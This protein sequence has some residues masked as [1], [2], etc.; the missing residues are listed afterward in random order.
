VENLKVCFYNFAKTVC[1]IKKGKPNKAFCYTTTNYGKN[2]KN[3]ISF[4]KAIKLVHMDV[5]QVSPYQKKKYLW[6]NINDEP[7]IEIHCWQLNKKK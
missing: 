6:K 2:I 3:S 4:E 7:K 5:N 1:S